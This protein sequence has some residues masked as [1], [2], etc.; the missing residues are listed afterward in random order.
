MPK[1]IRESRSL[2]VREA[3][4]GKSGRLKVGLITP[5]WGSSGYYSPKVLENAA[6]AKVFPAGTQ[7]FLDHETEAEKYERPERSVRDLAAVLTEDAT[8][9]GGQLVAEAQVFGPYVDL[10][11]DEQFASA[12]GVSIRAYADTTIGEAEGKKGRIITEL[13]EALSAD[14]VT[15]AGRGGQI[16]QVLESARPALVVERAVQHGVAEATANDTREAL[17]QA[18]REEYGGE[19][20]W[21]W[22]RDFDDTTVWF[23]W[24]TPDESATFAQSY[25]LQ[26]DGSVLLDGDRTEVRARTEYVPVTPPPAAESGT[27]N[28]PAPVGQPHPI[29]SSEENSMGTIQV[30][31][32][33]HGRLTEAAGRATEAERRATEA[34][35]AL[36]LYKAREG[37]RPVVASKVGESSLPPRRQSRVVEAVLAQV[38][39][40]DDGQ[41]DAAAVVAATEAAVKDAE[42]DIAEIAEALGAGKVT[43]FGHTNT[44]EVGEAD[45]AKAVASAF[46]RQVKEA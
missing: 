36:A 27:T 29:P 38:A 17:T 26:D 30:D 25:Q 41:V 24:E 15:K 5:G 11:A 20:A 19:Q 21:V 32:A 7:M 14:F 45:A 1:A 10:L 9:D 6:A 12:I 40:G 28:V 13:T 44:V 35:R 46:G 43:G 33:E 22:V 8:W 31:E 39:I 16:L 37:A 18:L 4:G 3:E 2:A 34:E 42:A 23:E